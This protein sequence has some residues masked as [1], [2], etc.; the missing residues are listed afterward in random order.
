MGIDTVK[1]DGKGFTV[2]VENG[3][4]VKK[5]DPLLK[6]DLD[7]ISKNAPSI[8]S[9]ILCTDLDDNMHIRLLKTGNVSAGEDLI[10]VDITE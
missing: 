3:Q 1:L 2:L 8:A 10:A 5:G 9:P 6:M 7:F 4:K